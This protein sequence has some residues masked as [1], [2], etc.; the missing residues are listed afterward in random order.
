MARAPRPWTVTRHGPLE[1]LD[2]NL[3]CVVGD[4]PGLAATRRMSIVRRS[5]GDLLFFNAMPLDQA[6]LDQVCA[7]GRPGFL[8]LGH[9]HHA[10]DGHAFRDRLGLRA[11]GPAACATE[12]AARLPLDGTLDELPA[13]PTVTVASVAG[14]KRGEA[15]AR[16][17][18]GDGRLSLLVTD[19]LQNSSPVGMP[20]FVRLLGFAGG[21]K[22]V[23]LFRTLFTADRRALAATIAGW[24]ELPGLCRL[25][26]SHGDVVEDGVAD[27]LRRAADAL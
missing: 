18:S 6:V 17:V 14:S 22:V 5:D 16:V 25:V 3:W 21:P 11:F 10:I 13:D 20:W 12:L 23:P 19:V 27:A 24:A 9:H 7:L 15:F 4:V 1:T 2:D 26:V 8:V